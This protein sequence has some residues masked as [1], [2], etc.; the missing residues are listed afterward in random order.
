MKHVFLIFLISV[1]TGIYSQIKLTENTLQFD[2]DAE[3][4]TV[5]IEQLSWYEGRWEGEGFGGMVE[6]N[7]G[8]PLGGTMIGTFRVI[9]ENGPSFYEMLI[10]EPDENSLVYKVKHFNPD[11]T[12]WEEKEDYVPFKLIKIEGNK[13]YFNGLTIERNGNKLTH[14]LALKQK[15]GTYR[16]EVLT[17]RKNGDLVPEDISP[18]F[19]N[20]PQ[21]TK[22]MLLGSYHM[23]NPG[24]DMFNLEAD[25]VL[26][27][28]RQEEIR[29]VVKNL[30]EF[31]PTKICI[32]SPYMDSA[33]IAKYHNYAKGEVELRR[34]EE[35]QIGFRLAKN[36]G[37]ETIY[38]IDVKM[39]IGQPEMGE[40]VSRNPE[41]FGPLMAEIE[42]FGKEAIK[43]MGEWLAEMTV[44][45]MLTM[46]NTK[47]LGDLNYQSYF[48][49]FMP[50]VDNES[51]AGADMVAEWTKRNIR[52]MSNLHKIGITSEDRVLIIFGQGHIPIFE[53][54]ANDSPL[55]EVVD[56]IPYLK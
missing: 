36:L 44:G 31:K 2:P 39:N 4:Q 19:E 10:I 51:Y 12:G 17:Y 11:F 47:T 48:Q 33:T 42:V 13:V 8:P 26:A 22:I 34:S 7:F 46:M 25:D 32:E 45:E 21:K 37:H 5:N 50:V 29:E 18:I 30:A 43:V 27:P 54:I 1:T 41:K 49:Y 52:I 3:R 55:L 53:R 38:P 6:E 9:S 14:Y 56:V 15:D 24:A 23:S 16:E 20:P 28:K 40:V 35:E